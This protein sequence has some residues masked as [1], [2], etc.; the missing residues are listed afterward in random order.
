MFVCVGAND[1][2][3]TEYIGALLENVTFS[4]V[5]INPAVE[6]HFI[7][8]FAIDYTT[9]SGSPVPIDGNFNIF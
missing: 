9:E 6:F 4:N 7:L 1:N 3:F 8:S 5:T 2:L